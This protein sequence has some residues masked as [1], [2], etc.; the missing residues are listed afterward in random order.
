MYNKME[1]VEQWMQNKCIE[2][3]ILNVDIMRVGFLLWNK[4]I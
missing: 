2:K 1:G 4:Y 3:E